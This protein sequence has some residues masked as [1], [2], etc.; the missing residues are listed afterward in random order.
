[1]TGQGSTPATPPPSAQ[2]GQTPVGDLPSAA[3]DFF[4]SPALSKGPPIFRD[5]VCE[6]GTLSVGT[7]ISEGP[8]SGDGTLPKRRGTRRR[9]K[10][11]RSFDIG[12]LQISERD[13][14]RLGGFA[15]ISD[16]GLSIDQTFF[17][18]IL[19]TLHWMAR[20]PG[21]KPLAE[22]TIEEIIHFSR[23]SAPGE[24]DAA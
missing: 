20:S 23:G 3:S 13:R 17:A 8:V 9:R 15:A 18:Q 10:G 2:G 14:A 5:P 24:S 1:M 19:W 21:I 16:A 22:W 6:D 7:Q 4:S 11:T 12:S